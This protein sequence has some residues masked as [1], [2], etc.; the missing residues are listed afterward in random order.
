MFDLPVKTK[1]ERASA[2]R[3]RKEL[4]KDGFVMLQYSV[5][6]RYCGSI[7]SVGVHTRRIRSLVPSKGFVSLLT[8]TDKQFSKIENFWGEIEEKKRP[9]PLQLEFF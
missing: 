7:E 2:A 1:K 6:I 5:Y 9:Q 4:E 3:F 8:V